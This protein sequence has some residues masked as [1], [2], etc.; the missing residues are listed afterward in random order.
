MSELKGLQKKVR[1]EK[2]RRQKE[3]E[4]E[5]NAKGVDIDSIKDWINLNTEQLLKQQELG[6]YLKKQVDAREEIEEEM[7]SEGDRLTELS[8]QQERLEFEQLAILEARESGEEYDEARDLEI[9]VELEDIATESSSITQTLDTLEEHLNFVNNKINKLKEEIASFDMDSIQAPRFKGLSSVE[10]A[11]KTLRT[12]FMV[13]L[14][15]NVYKRELET[16]L[17]EQ[18]EKLI[19][20]TT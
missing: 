8:I 14:D 10:M 1:E 4:K 18:D 7:F 6:T 15:L 12:F 20:L 9:E 3:E 13:L 17:I 5:M 2:E 19:E 16:K 11:R